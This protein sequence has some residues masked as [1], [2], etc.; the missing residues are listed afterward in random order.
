MEQEM[1]YGNDYKYIP[2]TSIASGAGLEVL[3]DLFCHTVQIVNICTVG[4]SKSDEFVLI[5]AGMPK[6]AD[7]IISVTE[8]RFGTNSRPKAIILTHGHFDHVGGIVTLLE[9]WETPVYAYPAEFMYLSGREAYDEPDTKVEGG[10]LA[11]ISSIYPHEPIDIT[12][13]LVPL[14]HSGNLPGLPGWKWIHTPGHTPGHVS[15]FRESDRT[16]IAG[17]AFVTVRTDSFYKV[18]IQKEEINGPPRYFTTDWDSAFESVKK[19]EALKPEIAITG[20]GPA[21]EGEEL[22]S[23]LKELVDDFYEVAVPMYGKYVK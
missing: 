10:L 12:P 16:L 20:H 23:G 5:D 3:P 11:K 22:R 6:S 9:E 17:D 19:L 4:N 21:M 13:A 1:R 18:I 14:P 2:T 15:F 8:E 7:E